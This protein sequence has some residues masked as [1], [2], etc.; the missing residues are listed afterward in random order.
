MIEHVARAVKYLLQT[1]PQQPLET[2]PQQRIQILGCPASNAA[3]KSEGSAVVASPFPKYSRPLSILLLCSNWLPKDQSRAAA[4][5]GCGGRRRVRSFGCAIKL[6]VILIKPNVWVPFSLLPFP[7]VLLPCYTFCVWTAS[8][9]VSHLVGEWLQRMAFLKQTE[10]KWCASAG[11]LQLI[12]CCCGLLVEHRA[13][14]RVIVF[15][16][17]CQKDLR[18]VKPTASSSGYCLSEPWT[19]P[20]SNQVPVMKDWMDLEE[21]INAQGSEAG[22]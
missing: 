15:A 5:E 10:L 13:F 19:Q 3:I 16:G 2:F 21:V 9:S 17:Q 1:S 11:P 12:H 8:H 14:Y 22:N 20:Q 7:L 6:K 4:V 18:P